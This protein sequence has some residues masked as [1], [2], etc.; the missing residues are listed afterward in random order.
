MQ[1]E[2]LCSR[3][4]MAGQVRG[5][6]TAGTLPGDLIGDYELAVGGRRL[7]TAA[8]RHGHRRRRHL[9]ATCPTRPPVTVAPA[10]Q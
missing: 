6:L 5:D 3:L 4:C 7:R 2:V 9:L 10:S 8:T 1:S